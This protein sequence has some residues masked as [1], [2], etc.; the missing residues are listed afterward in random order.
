MLSVVSILQTLR[1]H[2]NS[3]AMNKLL[4][5]FCATILIACNN[6]GSTTASGNKDTARNT[7]AVTTTNLST[8]TEMEILAECVDNAKDNAGNDLDD[9]RAFALCRCVLV[10]MQ[11]KYPGADSTALVNYLRDTTQVVQMARECQ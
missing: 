1:M 2:L 4:M 6:E 11:Q 8:E 10:H 5:L 7:A 3:Y 9:A